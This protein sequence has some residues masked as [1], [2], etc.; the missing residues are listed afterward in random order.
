M[1]NQKTVIGMAS[2]LVT[3]FS[4]QVF[5][6]GDKHKVDWDQVVN[7]M[8]VQEPVETQ[9]WRTENLKK[10]DEL[11]E[12]RNKYFNITYPKCFNAVPD[13]GEDDVKTAV[14]LML[15]KPST[16]QPDQKEAR[17]F[18]VS[19]T[20]D[21]LSKLKSV[22]KAHPGDRVLFKNK[23]SI[24]EN[25]AVLFAGVYGQKEHLKGRWSIYV[26]CSEKMFRIVVP[27]G[28]GKQMISFLEKGNFEL[29]DEYKKI[30]STFKCAKK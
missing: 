20:W 5:A 17:D 3:L 7:E 15:Q 13:C 2:I 21:Y 9:I 18:E 14:C 25:A 19:I 16:C 8:K 4:I 12:L 23:V 26:L 11:F 27:I 28:E 24:N 22:E 6:E 1:E 10:T 30:V 29:P